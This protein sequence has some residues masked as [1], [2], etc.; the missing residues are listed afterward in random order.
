MVEKL[1]STVNFDLI[2]CQNFY[3]ISFVKTNTQKKM[4]I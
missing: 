3:K 2:F 1:M 4:T